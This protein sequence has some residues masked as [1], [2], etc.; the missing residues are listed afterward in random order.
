MPTP[1]A[2]R[3]EDLVGNTPLVRLRR[4]EQDAPGVEIYGKAEFFNPGG[5]VKDRPALNMILEGEKAGLLKPGKII[6]DATSGNTGIAYAMIGAA[7][8]YKV[9]LCLPRNVS[10]ERKKILAAYGAEI[11]YTSPAE[12][13]DGAIRMVKKLYA[14]NPEIYFYPDQYGNDN[15]WLAHYKSTG[16]EIWDQT[17]G[18]VTHFVAGLGTTGTMMGTGRYLKQVQPQVQLVAMQPDSP[19]NGLEGLKHLETAIVP[20]IY[21]PT[22]ADQ[23]VECRTEDAYVMVKRLAREEGLL[24]GISAGGNVHSALQI[25]KTAPRGSVVVT[26]LCDGADRYLSERFWTEGED[27]PHPQI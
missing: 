26:I 16:P 20:P 8:G 4:I 10:P 22:V 1:S 17:E 2:H 23:N 9:R 5:S 18:R 24:V 6:L 12:Q 15:N 3:L 21:D 27:E 14:E 13:S 7:R 25:A 11:V 19:F